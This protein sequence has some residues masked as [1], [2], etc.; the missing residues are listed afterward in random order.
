M[1]PYSRMSV[2]QKRLF[3]LASA[4]GTAC[5]TQSELA[6]LSST[7]ISDI[8]SGRYCNPTLRVLWSL[9]SYFHVSVDWLI[10]FDVR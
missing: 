6:G 2:F 10:G 7:M 1:S 3:A 8:L 9:A 5:R 4:S